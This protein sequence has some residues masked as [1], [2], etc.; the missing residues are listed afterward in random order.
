MVR[1]VLNRDSPDWH[2]RNACP[3]CMYRLKDEKPLLYKL[4]YEFD[5]NDSLKLAIRR[6]LSDNDEE[7]VGPVN[8]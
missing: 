2:L 7:P 3:A 4:F 1:T 6:A 5:G 8:E